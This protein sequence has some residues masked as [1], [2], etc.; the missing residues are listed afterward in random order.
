L[1]VDM[2]GRIVLPNDTAM[3]LTLIVN[4][5][6]TNVVRRGIRNRISDKV[7]VS[8]TESDGQLFLSIEDGGEGFDLAAV[9][10]RCSGRQ[11]VSGLARQLQDS[12]EVTRNP[13]MA[14]LR[15]PA[16]GI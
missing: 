6:V 4:E 5:L 9:R 10:R 1:K 13:S 3:P 11:L 14:R 16:S 8:L 15:F 12:F 7:G 2:D